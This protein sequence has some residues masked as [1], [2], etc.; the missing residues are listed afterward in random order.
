MLE[1]SVP[2]I[3][4]TERDSRTHTNW[5]QKKSKTKEK[6]S[7]NGYSKPDQNGQTKT[8]SP[9]HTILMLRK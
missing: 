3:V 7:E 4:Q 5:R 8:D 1:K 9:S 6:I 2:T